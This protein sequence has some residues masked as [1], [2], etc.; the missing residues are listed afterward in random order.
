[1]SWS[2]ETHLGALRALSL[3]E[4]LVRNEG[5]LM[6]GTLVGERNSRARGFPL[7]TE[8]SS[9]V[10]LEEGLEKGPLRRALER[11]PRASCQTVRVT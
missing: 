4:A 7:Q 1:M 2:L 3:G 8:E 11:A 10:D 6:A 9:E 5:C